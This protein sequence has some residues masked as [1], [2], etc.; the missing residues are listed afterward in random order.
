VASTEVINITSG[1]R[2]MSINEMQREPAVETSRGYDRY[3]P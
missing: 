2:D 3:E 1:Q